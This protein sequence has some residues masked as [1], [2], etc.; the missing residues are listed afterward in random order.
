MKFYLDDGGHTIVF[1]YKDSQGTTHPF[2]V[3]NADIV[4]SSGTEKSKEMLERILKDGVT[5]LRDRVY[6]AFMGPPIL[7][8][9][10]RCYCGHEINVGRDDKGYYVEGASEII[11][12]PWDKPLEEEGDDE[13]RA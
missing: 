8:Y 7:S 3:E 1:F 12:E 6:I 13:P 11:F 5:A 9:K 2:P 4:R 10:V